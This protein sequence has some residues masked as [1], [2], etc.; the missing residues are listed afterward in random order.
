[1]NLLQ[2]QVQSVM[3]EVEEIES[4]QSPSGRIVFEAIALEGVQE[5]ERSSAALGWSGLAAGL[6]MGFSMISEGL[7]ASYLPD[8]TWRPLIAKLGYSVGFVVVVLGR[9]QLFTENTLTPILPLLKHRSGR[10]FA[11]VMRLWGI[12]LIAN[13]L[14]ALAVGAAAINTTAFEPAVRHGFVE[15]GRSALEH[16]FLTAFVR[17]IFAGW[18]IALMVWLLPFA[19]SARVGVIV[20]IT[21][22]VGIGNFGHIIAGSVE[23]FA[24]AA[25]GYAGWWEVLSRFVLPTLLG[26]IVGGVLLVAMLNYAQIVAGEPPEP[27]GRSASGPS[28]SSLKARSRRA[29]TANR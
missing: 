9:Q 19:E 5:L 29:S 12:V 16:G 10:M 24:L 17:A 4:R 7:L 2:A 27:E 18:L 25:G 6:S 14:G 11:N 8:T 1:M 22:V 3:D 15:M 13:L 28:R 20:L 23:V 21:Y 26:N